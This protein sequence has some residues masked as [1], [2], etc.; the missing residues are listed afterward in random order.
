MSR[1]TT[2]W[3]LPIIIIIDQ[4][5]KW[6]AGRFDLVRINSGVAFGLGQMADSSII[7]AVMFLGL[8]GLV[9]LYRFKR[10][11]QLGLMLILSGGMSNLID[12]YY[13]SGVRD[14]LPM[15]WW[16]NN[17]ADLAIF[18]GLVLSVIQVYRVYV[19]T[20]KNYV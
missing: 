18:C 10:P 5:T 12:R 3:W 6:L 8:V 15:M 20:K 14:F 4:T 9:F 2:T 11:Y 17:L 7:M 1:F 19:L 16:H 13:F